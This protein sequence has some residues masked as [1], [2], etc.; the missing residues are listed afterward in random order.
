MHLLLW[1]NTFILRGLA[2]IMYEIDIRSFA[3]GIYDQLDENGKRDFNKLLGYID[4]VL[5]IIKKLGINRDDFKELL[6][7]QYREQLE[8]FK[9]SEL[10][11]VPK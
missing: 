5:G 11:G 7:E 1:L 6:I 3:K 9:L 4:A 2:L 8:A 10:K